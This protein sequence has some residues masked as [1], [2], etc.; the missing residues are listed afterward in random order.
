M[1]HARFGYLYYSMPMD[2]EYTER[3]L[4]TTS[5]AATTDIKDPQTVLHAAFN[6][7]IG[8]NFDA[9]GES[10]TDDV[11][12]NIRGFGALDGTW[13]G[14]QEV[15]AATRRN[16][17]LLASQ[18]PQIESMISQG[19]SVAVLLRESGVLKS[20]GRAYNVRGVQWFTFA[21]GKIS[22]IDEIVAAVS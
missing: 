10:I 13:R 9:F 7:I 19:D 5:S 21:D 17:D 6:A 1:H 22:K 4:R 8:G 2:R 3:L 15:V 14:R 20:N 18:K 11:E 16:F 12:L